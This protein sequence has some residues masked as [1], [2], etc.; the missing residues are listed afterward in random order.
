MPPKR[1][2][3]I[4]MLDL[5]PHMNTTGSKPSSCLSVPTVPPAG[6]ISLPP[7]HRQAG[8]AGTSVE[9]RNRT[10]YFPATNTQINSINGF[11]NKRLKSD[12][13]AGR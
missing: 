5:Q 4:Y 8:R 7:R 11:Q 1:K 2:Y 10:M 12:S 13:L 3:G 9:I 6:E